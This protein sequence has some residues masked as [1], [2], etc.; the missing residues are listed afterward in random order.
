ML[1]KKTQLM[2]AGLVLIAVAAMVYI[3]YVAFNS[4]VDKLSNEMSSIIQEDNS[5]FQ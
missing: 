5:F 2:L 3:D 1:D 4:V